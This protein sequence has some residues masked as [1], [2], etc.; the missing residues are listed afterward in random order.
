MWLLFFLLTR[1]GCLVHQ[2]VRGSSLIVLCGDFNELLPSGR[3]YLWCVF[4]LF[5][6]LECVI[7]CNL[8]V[9]YGEE[10]KWML[11]D[12]LWNRL[13]FCA[14]RKNSSFIFEAIRAVRA[15]LDKKIISF[16]AFPL[17]KPSE[18]PNREARAKEE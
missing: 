16:G 1:C 5:R 13:F 2:R 4:L 10:V 15:R 17:L 12:S 18:C 9:I 3:V 6:F 8:C 11:L 7:V 14:R